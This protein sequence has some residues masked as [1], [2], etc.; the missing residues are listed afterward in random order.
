MPIT[1]LSPF[2]ETICQSNKT[3]KALILK[4][5]NQINVK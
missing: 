5:L 4:K 1:T 2:L 3:L